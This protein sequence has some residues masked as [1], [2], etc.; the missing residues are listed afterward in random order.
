MRKSLEREEKLYFS[1]TW[2]LT[3]GIF[4]HP[5]CF[6][7]NKGPQLVLL[8]CYLNPVA[9]YTE[10]PPQMQLHKGFC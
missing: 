4:A 7:A 6:A 5:G 3:Q 9:V 2:G 8:S 1:A 10:K